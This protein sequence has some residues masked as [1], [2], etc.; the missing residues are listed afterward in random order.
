MRITEVETS[1]TEQ[2]ALQSS[3]ADLRQQIVALR[4]FVE[5][6]RLPWYESSIRS[7]SLASITQTTQLLLQG[8]YQRLLAEGKA[9]PSLTDV[10]FRCY[11]QTGE[12]GIIHYV[13]AVLGTGP[14]KAVEVCAGNGLECNSANLI[15][16]HGWDALLFDGD[17][18]NIA[19]AKEFYRAC[20]DTC[21]R[22]PTLVEAW[23]TAENVDALIAGN[24]YAGEIGLLSVD[25]DGMDYWIWRAIRGVSPR[26]VVVEFNPS[27]GPE[28]SV[29]VPY[30][31]NFRMD[32]SKAPY[33]TGASLTA[34]CKLAQEKG[35]RLIGVNRLG[36]NA[37]FLR[38][39]LRCDVFP[40]LSPAECFRMNAFL[41]PWSP[42][43]I[44]SASDRPEFHTVTE[45]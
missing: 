4:N 3:I 35:Y 11:S 44:P 26:L 40:A 28:L 5:S 14:R 27:W 39:D 6:Q 23:I 13:F 17:A 33:Y 34:F 45:I 37:F 10:E 12:D 18:N 24:G 25:V 2:G 31:P 21:Y 36:F 29:S 19:A 22:P 30:D 8:H 41:Q 15:V 43:W 32:F 38:N 7:N 42:S 16:N 1:D 9:M 20:R